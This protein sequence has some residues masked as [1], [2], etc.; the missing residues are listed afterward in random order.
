[1]KK[2]VIAIIIALCILLPL[3]MMYSFAAEATNGTVITEESLETGYDADSN[4][5]TASENT[6]EEKTDV[7]TLPDGELIEDEKE[8]KILN[9]MFFIAVIVIVVR[10]FLFIVGVV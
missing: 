3:T 2:R 10:L 7:F 1:M 6:A 9:T 5:A 4:I 8:I